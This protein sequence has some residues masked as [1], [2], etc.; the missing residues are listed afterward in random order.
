MDQYIIFGIALILVVALL[1]GGIDYLMPV[2]AKI[3]MND[4]CRDYAMIVAADGQLLDSEKD[5]L[6]DELAS[7]GIQEVKLNLDSRAFKRKETIHFEVTGVYQGNHFISIFK[8][9]VKAYDF[10]F[11]EDVAYRKIWNH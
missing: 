3:S 5:A 8:R 2:Y 1:V 10:V 6:K 4:T 11:E 7:R 9:G